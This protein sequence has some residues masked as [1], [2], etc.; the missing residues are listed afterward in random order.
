MNLIGLLIWILVLGLICWLVKAYI[1]PHIA[2]P[3]RTIFII[4]F[5]AIV[6]L[7]SLAGMLVVVLPEI[8]LR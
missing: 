7:L 2:E 8:R 1:L 3:F 5:I 6:W 4:V